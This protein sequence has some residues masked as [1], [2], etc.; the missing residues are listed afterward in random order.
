MVV[1]RLGVIGSNVGIKVRR[2]VLFGL[3]FWADSIA[4]A[5]D[6]ELAALVTWFEDDQELD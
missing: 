4:I 1:L 5:Q 2:I 6:V 3:A